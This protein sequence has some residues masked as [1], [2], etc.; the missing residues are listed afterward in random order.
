MAA[1]VTSRSAMQGLPEKV[2]PKL[3]RV[4][5]PNQEL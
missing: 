5:R 2:G 1:D 4:S 3:S